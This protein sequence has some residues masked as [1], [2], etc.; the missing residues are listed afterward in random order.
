[1]RHL[2][3]TSQFKRDFKKVA[4][5]ERYKKQDF[6][7]IVELLINDQ[8]LPEKNRDHTLINDW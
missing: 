5:S 3:Q 2:E 6:L 1:M 8:P 7:T 4:S